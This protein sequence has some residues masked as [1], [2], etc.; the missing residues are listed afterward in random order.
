MYVPKTEEPLSF[1]SLCGA[2]D[3]PGLGFPTPHSLQ[4]TKPS[5]SSG[6]HEKAGQSR[7]GDSGDI[8]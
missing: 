4:Q 7:L 8:R 1:V 3:W 5:G 2:Q 6:N